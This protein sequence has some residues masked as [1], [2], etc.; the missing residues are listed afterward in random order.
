MPR[1]LQRNIG[2]ETQSVVGVDQLP[3]DALTTCTCLPSPVDFEN[4]GIN[5]K[6]HVVINCFAKT[7]SPLLA[8]DCP[9]NPKNRNRNQ[10]KKQT[11]NHNRSQKV[12]N[13]NKQSRVRPCVVA[14]DCDDGDE[15]V[16]LMMIAMVTSECC[17]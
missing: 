10:K 2:I 6:L 7:Q 1:R 11:T 15:L 4:V 13:A 8:R 9:L 12:K 17:C 16:L 5:I 3:T 14:D